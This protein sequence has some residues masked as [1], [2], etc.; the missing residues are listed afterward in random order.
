M[1]EQKTCKLCERPGTLA[2]PIHE[3]GL[4]TDCECEHGQIG[5]KCPLCWRNAQWQAMGLLEDGEWP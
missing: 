1:S 2:N 4:H 3:N 5:Y